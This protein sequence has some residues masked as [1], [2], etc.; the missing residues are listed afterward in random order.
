MKVPIINDVG[1]NT[2]VKNWWITHFGNKL[3][4]YINTLEHRKPSELFWGC[5]YRNPCEYI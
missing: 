5:C 1:G 2:N 4:I 3:F